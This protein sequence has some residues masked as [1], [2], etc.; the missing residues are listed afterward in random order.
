[1]AKLT[2]RARLI[3][4]KVEVTKNYEI[5]EAVALLKE[6]AT[7]KFVE[8]VDVA[9]NLGVDPRKSDQN[10]RGATV[11]PHGTGREVR[12]AVFTQGANAEAATEAGAELVGMDELAAQVKAGEMNFDV[13]IASPDAMRVV[14]QLGQILGPRGLMPNPKTGT[15]TPNVAEAVKNA[16]AGQVRYRND[17]NGIIHSTIGKVDFEPAQLKENLEALLVALVKAKPASAKGV[18]LKKVSIS[19]TMGA[20]VAVDQASLTTSS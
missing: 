3:R 11:L 7:A 4:E 17:K 15:V 18:F 8:S 13:V 12:V 14:G 20:G 10:V 2:K 9:V 19:T 6:L 5:N 1:M 16:K